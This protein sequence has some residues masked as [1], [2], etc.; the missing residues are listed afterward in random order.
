M[1]A[2]PDTR[3]S[4]VGVVYHSYGYTSRLQFRMDDSDR[5]SME[6]WCVFECVCFWCWRFALV[7]ESLLGAEAREAMVRVSRVVVQLQ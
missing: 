1:N 4:V 5:A 6:Q 7:D 3:L 2:E